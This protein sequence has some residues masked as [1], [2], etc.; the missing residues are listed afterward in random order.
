[1][2]EY[3]ELLESIEV[4][5]KPKGYECGNIPKKISNI[6]KLPLIQK[7]IAKSRNNRWNKAGE[8]VDDENIIHIYD[9]M[10]DDNIIQIYNITTITNPSEEK[11][12]NQYQLDLNHLQQSNQDPINPQ[13]IFCLTLSLVTIDRV[14]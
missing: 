4:I 9:N 11:P 14:V 8:L 7:Q 10:D 2:E 13:L 3:D 1:M 12:P 6:H 5:K